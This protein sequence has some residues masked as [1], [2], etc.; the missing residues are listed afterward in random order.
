[1]GGA[2]PEVPD[3]PF[4]EFSLAVYGRAGVAAACLSLQD[5]RGLDVNL[6]LFCC[7]AGSRG[8]KLADADLARLMAAAGPWQAHVVAPVRAARRWLKAEAP[9]SAL[10]QCLRTIELEA[11]AMEQRRLHDTLPLAASPGE[12]GLA[13]GNMLAYLTVLG[14]APEA[15]DVADLAAILRG[16]YPDLAPLQA[17]WA[18]TD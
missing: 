16:C 15:T 1:V 3:N 8:R 10:R 7:W 4:W 12:P 18:V 6:V 13:G 5:R 9:E 17:I 14:I 11:E 2:A